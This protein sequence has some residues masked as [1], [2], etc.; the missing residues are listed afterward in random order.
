MISKARIR[1]SRQQSRTAWFYAFVGPWLLG[2]V[3]LTLLPV[4]IGLLTSFSNYDGLNLPTVRFV[5]LRNYA[6]VFTVDKDAIFAFGQTLRWTALNL[7][8]WMILSF[9]LAL[10]LNQDVK[11]RGF[12]RTAF[13]LPSVM[14]AVA[15]VWVWRIILDRNVGLLNAV[16]SLF[17]PNTA[18]PWLTTYA[19]PGLTMI[20]VWTGL[21]WGM[22]IFLAALQGIPEELVEAARIDGAG[23]LQIFRHVTIPLMTP[24][25]FFVLVNGLVGSFQQYVLPQLL[26]AGA[27]IS[28]VPPRAVYLSLTH[29][30]LQVFAYQRF[31]YGT[32]LLWLLFL[33][34]VLIT[35]LVFRTARFWVYTEAG[36]GGK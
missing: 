4:G 9:I 7:P 20:A 25:I 14:P 36:D 27:Q 31:G 33:V 29:V 34:I 17:R 30:N 12:F 22:I 11:G 24:V 5:G 13:Y 15:L 28:G 18:I 3:F 16:I 6:R 32:A 21:G 1:L 19:L 23:N 26:T 35:I 2:L 10:I 8:A